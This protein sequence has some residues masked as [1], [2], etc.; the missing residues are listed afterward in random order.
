MK[1]VAEAYLGKSVTHAVVTVPAY[2][3][4]GQ[5]G[6][7]SFSPFELSFSNEKRRVFIEY[8]LVN[9]SMWYHTA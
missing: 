2:F 7:L 6:V 5:R 9:V 4:D 1:H 3:D 8:L